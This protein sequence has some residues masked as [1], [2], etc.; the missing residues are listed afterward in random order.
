MCL[1]IT[2]FI[3]FWVHQTSWICK[4]MFFLKFG[5]VPAIISSHLKFFQYQSLPPSLVVSERHEC[6][7]FWFCITGLCISPWGYILSFFFPVDQ[8][9]LILFIC[10]QVQ[11]LTLLSSAY[12][13][14]PT[15]WNFYFSCIFFQFWSF[16]LAFVVPQPFFQSF[17]FLAHNIY[18]ST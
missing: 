17:Y 2:F 16:H 13:I 15:Q 11:W 3:F 6:Q 14:E 4:F 5:R 7:T 9:W 18:L 12:V 8:I 10:V 1:S